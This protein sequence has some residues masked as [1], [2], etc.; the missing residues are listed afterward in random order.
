MSILTSPTL[1][2]L[3]VDVR[4]MLNQQS[5][6][7]SFWSDEEVTG[8][9]NEGV[10]RY[11]QEVVLL[12]S[13]QFMVLA[14]LNLVNGVE[15]VAFPT[16]CFEIKALYKSID[17]GQRY[18]IL[19]YDNNV[20]NGYQTQASQD[21]SSYLPSYFFRGNNFVLRP[22]PQFSETAGL[23]VEFVQFPDMMVNGGDA[24]TNQ[25][26]PVFKDLIVMY[27]VYK[28]K[29]KESLVNGVNVHLPAQE[30]VGNLYASFKDAI[31]QRTAYPKY[32][33]PFNPENF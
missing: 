28:A 12:Y 1:D 33:A 2:D 21:S 20:T 17:S 18:E 30:N 24:L 16:G 27:A 9:L 15:T 26:A 4:N 13:G 19:T 14:D 29:L 7:N 31:Q 3:I 32:I 25:V 6:N 8:Y 22:A 5:A 10:R 11:F 23:R